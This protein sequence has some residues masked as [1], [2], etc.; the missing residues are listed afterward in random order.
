MTFKWPSSYVHGKSFQCKYLQIEQ[1]IVKYFSTH[2]IALQDLVRLLNELF[3]RFDQLANDNRCLRIKILGDLDCPTSSHT[4]P[5]YFTSTPSFYPTRTP[6]LLFALHI[7][8][9]LILV[10]IYV[11]P[12]QGPLWGPWGPWGPGACQRLAP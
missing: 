9:V 12:L 1:V 3:G 10:Y 4:P 7:L 2:C 8:L 11:V 6:V 5:P